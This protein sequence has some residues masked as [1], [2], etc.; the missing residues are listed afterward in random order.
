MRGA[1]DDLY[2][3]VELKEI[4]AKINFEKEHPAPSYSQLV[5][6]REWCRMWI[7]I[8]AVSRQLM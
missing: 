2:V 3:Q 5:F 1:I 7:G 6:G 8:G 4:I